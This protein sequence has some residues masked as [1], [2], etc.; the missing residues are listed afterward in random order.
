[1][2][3]YGMGVS[4]LVAAVIEQHHDEKGCLWTK[5]T[6]PYEL[7]ILVSNIKDE[8]QKAFGEELYKKLKDAGVNVLLDDRPERFGFKMKDFELLG[9]PKAVIVGKGLVDG[10]VQIVDRKT[11]QKSVVSKDE[12]FSRLVE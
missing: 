12:I 1:M 8:E 3:T 2:G 7:F 9:F 11:S 10:E 4:R 5:E 6:T